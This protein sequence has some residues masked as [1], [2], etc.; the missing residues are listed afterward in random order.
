VSLGH[1]RQIIAAVSTP[2]VAVTVNLTLERL[3]QIHEKLHPAALQLHGD[4]SPELV[5][6]LKAQGVLVWA[7]AAGDPDNVRRR[8][9]ELTEA[10][11]DAVL[12]DV[13]ATSL[14]GI[15]YGGTGQTG[16]WGVARELVESGLRVILAGGLT[17][18]NVTEA[19]S[20]VRPWMVDVISGV[21]ARKGQ[22]DETK[23]R[24]FVET[25]RGRSCGHY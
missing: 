11:A 3:L 17:P 5:R 7:V 2:V 10:G 21:E 9:L 15:I 12:L 6:Q 24:Q 23:V 4:E 20:A 8:A 13:R 14:D 22:K 1:A 19:V 18:E 25:A 16:D